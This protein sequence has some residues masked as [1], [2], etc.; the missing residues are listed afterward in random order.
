MTKQTIT[1]RS[2]EE[3][4]AAAPKKTKVVR[5]ATK[6]PGEAA[7]EERP[8]SSDRQASVA[9]AIDKA[10]D[11]IRA[12]LTTDEL[13]ASISDLVRLI[14]LRK[15]MSDDAPKHVTVRWVEEWNQSTSTEE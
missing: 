3:S 13:R 7:A 4:K 6:A 15:E 9:D 10:I 5:K 14:Q 11:S 8:V 2:A 12:K 1:K